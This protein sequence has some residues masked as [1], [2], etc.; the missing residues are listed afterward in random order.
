MPARIVIGR[1]LD[2]ADQQG[3]LV[4]R[5]IGEI[6]AEVELAGQPE[7][8]DGTQTIL[9]EED[10]IE[11]GLENLLLVVVQLQQHRHH[12]LGGL[13][14][15]AAFVG[16]V[17]VLHQLL[18]QRTAALTHRAGR[19]VH[20]N[21]TGDGLG[22]NAEVLEELPILDCHQRL[23]QIGRHLIQLDQDAVLVVRRIKAADQH[24]LQARN[25]QAG[26]VSAI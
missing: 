21:G 2:H 18:R 4:Q 8:M 12:R 3:D 7:A 24:R 17:K 14:R 9:A 20:P 26:A 13:A 16:E 25:G 19:Q 10:L 5:Q 22:R 6:A 23:D 15:Q 11:V 1:P